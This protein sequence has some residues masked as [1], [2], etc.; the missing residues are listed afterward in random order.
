MS[1]YLKASWRNTLAV[2]EFIY[3]YIYIYIPIMII[4]CVPT[5]PEAELMLAGMG[6]ISRGHKGAF[7]PGEYL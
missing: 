5:A 2:G 6:G 7:L 3:V 4:D 1:C